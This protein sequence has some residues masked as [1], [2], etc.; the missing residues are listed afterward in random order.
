ME[1]KVKAILKDGAVL[2]IRSTD[3]ASGYNIV[4]TSEPEIKGSDVYFDDHYKTYNRVDYIQYRTG[5]FVEP[6]TDDFDLCIFP[7][8]SVSK[9]NLILH[10]SIGLLDV[11]YRGEVLVRFSYQ[12]QPEDFKVVQGNVIGSINKERIYKKGDQIAQLKS[13]P[14][15][16]INWE[17]TF[18]VSETERGAKGFGEQGGA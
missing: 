2:P 8:S 13:T 12:W 11:D 10:N 1:I 7:R 3:L 16:G 14:I 15:V 18:E 4:A 9:Y 6:E 17:E 5:L